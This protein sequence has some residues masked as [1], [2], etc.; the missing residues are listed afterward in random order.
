MTNSKPSPLADSVLAST[1]GLRYFLVLV[2]LQILS[3]NHGNFELSMH[4]VGKM[5]EESIKAFDFSPNKGDKV[6]DQPV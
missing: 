1:E 4:L 2:K 5:I 6:P 3:A